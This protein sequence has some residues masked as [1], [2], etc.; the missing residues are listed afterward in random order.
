[1]QEKAYSN[2][3]KNSRAYPFNALEYALEKC[4][5]MKYIEL[6]GYSID[7]LS[8]SCNE[9]ENILIGCLQ[10]LRQPDIRVAVIQ[11]YFRDNLSLKQTAEALGFTSERI[12]QLLF[13]SSRWVCKNFNRIF[14]AKNMRI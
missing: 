4:R 12:R 9:L 5:F 2:K 11:L 1:M 7:R 6:D 13:S 14:N 8:L 3:K 10:E